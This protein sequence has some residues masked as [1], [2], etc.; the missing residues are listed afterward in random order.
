MTI[1]SGTGVQLWSV[2]QSLLQMKD[3]HKDSWEA[4]IGSCGV[5]TAFAPA[6]T[7]TAEYI[8][9]LC[10]GATYD[11]GR[12]RSRD[13]RESDRGKR[14]NESR[15]LA[16]SRSLISPAEL[17]RIPSGQMLCLIEPD[18]RPLVSDV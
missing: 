8:W 6:D 4:V 9:R 1:G 15:N 10:G 17:T 16:T 2:F 7:F 11:R 5:I 13:L 3:V 18:K 12:E 14:Q